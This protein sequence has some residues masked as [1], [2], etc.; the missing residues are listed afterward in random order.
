[1][2]QFC[3]NSKKIEFYD[4]S[5]ARDSSGKWTDGGSGS[6]EKTPDTDITSNKNSQAPSKEPEQEIPPKLEKEKVAEL[7]DEE[8]KDYQE[9]WNRENS[10]EKSEQADIHAEELKKYAQ[11]NNLTEEQFNNLVREVHQFGMGDSVLGDRIT[12][13]M[14]PMQKLNW[15]IKNNQTNES[16]KEIIKAIDK[17]AMRPESIYLYRGLHDQGGAVNISKF[18]R[19]KEGQTISLNQISS[20]SQKKSIAEGFAT[21]GSDEN[22]SVILSLVNKNRKGL[23][24]SLLQRE[25]ENEVMMPY[26]TKFKV[27]KVTKKTYKSEPHEVEIDGDYFKI[28][29][30]SVDSIEIHGEVL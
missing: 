2:I 19:I 21:Q 20:F 11:E 16:Q 29:R 17:G 18:K 4:D 14:N 22:N 24:V 10:Q 13:E 27:T 23:S 15:A 8:R 30:K 26:N 5:Q 6:I 7:I 12:S 9:T 25:D 3:Y 28:N 1:V